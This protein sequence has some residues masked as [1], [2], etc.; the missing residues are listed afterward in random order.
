MN[1]LRPDPSNTVPTETPDAAA[2]PDDLELVAR[3]QAGDTS[4]FNELVIRY[5]N[6]AYAMIYNMVRNEQ[7]AWDL[8]QD[9]FLKAWKSINRF[10]GQSSFYTWLY[11]ILMNVAIDSLRKKQIEGGQEFD[12]QIGLHNIAPG[13]A[14]APKSEMEPAERISDKEIRQ[15]IDEAIAKLSPE[16]RTAIV[17]R[18]I[19]GLEYTEIAEQMGCSL[20]TVMSR[21]FYARK[22]LQALLKDVYETI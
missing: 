6:R 19:D 7:D 13:A 18:E 4:A 3:S 9:G 5:R 11:R 14:T 15:R 10:R 1:E 16:H 22:K 12:D 8:A 21:L 17:M 2:G 20:G